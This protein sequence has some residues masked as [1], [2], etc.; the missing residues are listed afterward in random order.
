MNTYLS[1]LTGGFLNFKNIGSGILGYFTSVK[2]Q[3]GGVSSALGGV[4]SNSTLFTKIGSVFSG[5]GG[6]I[7]GTVMGAG[8]KLLNLFLSPFTRM[9]GKLGSMSGV[10]TVIANS[11]LGKV[12]NLVGA[13][14][15]K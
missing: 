3:T 8:S 9:G 4:L 15:G 5:I 7:G 1:S 2:K 11:P 12:G 14:L 6:K 13:G 10:G